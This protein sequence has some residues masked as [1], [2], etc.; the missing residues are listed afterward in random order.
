MIKNGTTLEFSI[1]MPAFNEEKVIE[2]TLRG[3]I[4]ELESPSFTQIS[5]FEIIVTDDGSSDQTYNKLEKLSSQDKRI[6]VFRHNTNKGFGSAVMNGIRQA[7]GKKLLLVPSDG[8]FD[9]GEIGKFID[10]LD[11]YDLVIGIRPGREGY[12]I[13]RRFVS[14]V[15]ISLVKIL[16]GKSFRDTNWVQAWKKEIFNKVD[17]KSTGVFFLQETITLTGRA[18][19]KTGEIDSKHIAR[20]KGQAS[21]G[22]VSVIL[23]TLYEMLKFRLRA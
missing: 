23:F 21:G 3:L 19:Y 13:F 14:F 2:E 10:A 17:P 16:F 12:G 4:R 7:E 9:P 5:G 20:E 22:K 6:R 1:I 15:Y 8:Q 11:E 18:G